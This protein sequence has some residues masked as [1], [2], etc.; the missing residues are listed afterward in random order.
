MRSPQRA[1]E[2]GD[3]AH[4]AVSWG[5]DGMQLR[6]DGVLDGTAAPCRRARGQRRALGDRGERQRLG[7]PAAWA[8]ARPFPRDDRRGGAVRPPARRGGP[9]GARRGRG[10]R[11]G[12]ATPRQWSLRCP[13]RSATVGQAFAFAPP[14]DAFAD[15]DGDALSL[16]ATTTAGDALPGWLGFDGVRFTGTPPAGGQGD[17]GAARHRLGRRATVWDDFV[18]TI[19]AAAPAATAELS[20][21]GQTGRGK[22]VDLARG[23]WADA[24]RVM[25]LGDSNTLGLSNVLPSA[26]LESYRARALVAGDRGPV[27]DRLRR[28]PDS[29]GPAS[30][31]DRSHQGVSGIRAT[32]VV[33]QA[34]RSRHDAPARRRA[35][36]ARHQRRAERGERGRP[37]F[38]ASCCRSCA[39]DAVQP[40]VTILLA[41]LPP[42]DPDAPG[43]TKRADAD[44]I[45]AAINAQLPAL[46]AQARGRAS[47]RASCRCRTSARATSTTAST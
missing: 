24:P 9:R 25:P 47:T 30:L 44:D 5:A 39:F 16:T 11:W 15:P 1:L 27:L 22:K 19:D 20:F 41:P 40:D 23:F 3:W 12:G 17:A 38:R 33:G 32:Q 4:V 36:D 45:R 10:R 28:R 8:A 7:E 18:L 35:A 34:T 43:Y 31:P 29:N 26:Q 42:I 14:A 46:A 2:A 6:L 13:D 21:A 37:R